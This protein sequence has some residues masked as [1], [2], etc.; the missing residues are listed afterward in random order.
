MKKKEKEDE[1]WQKKKEKYEKQEKQLQK[2]EEKKIKKDKVSNS[3]VDKLLSKY[4]TPSKNPENYQE[5]SKNK[6]KSKKQEPPLLN[7]QE[8][9]EKPLI[10][11]LKLSH[12]SQFE[13]SQKEE[14]Q[15]KEEKKT[16]KSK[17]KINIKK[18]I[19]EEPEQIEPKT[20]IKKTRS[21]ESLKGED[22]FLSLGNTIKSKLQ[23]QKQDKKEKT[24]QKPAK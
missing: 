11:R 13:Q 7:T 8:L 18:D 17:K 3:Q 6:K 16:Q 24:P 19:K 2:K 10:E 12:Q 23:K 21:T 1:Q 15:E 5:L 4:T 9:A 14:K 20:T 22:L